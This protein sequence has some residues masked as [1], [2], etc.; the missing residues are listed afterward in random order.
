MTTLNEALTWLQPGNKTFGWGGLLM[1]SRNAVNNALID[2]YLSRRRNPFVINEYVADDD[3]NLLIQ[4][5]DFEFG[6][7]YVSFHGTVFNDKVLKGYMDVISGKEFSWGKNNAGHYSIFKICSIDN[8]AD[9]RIEFPLEIKPAPVSSEGVMSVVAEIK[10]NS[11]YSLTGMWES[12]LNKKAGGV[13]V[14]KMTTLSAGAINYQL[15]TI[16]RSPEVNDE[17]LIR[18]QSLKC[19]VYE[20][21]PTSTENNSDY[22]DGA[23]I[24]YIKTPGL[25]EPGF[26]AGRDQLKYLLADDDLLSLTLSKSNVDKYANLSNR[27]NGIASFARDQIFPFETRVLHH[28][29]DTYLQGG[30]G[31]ITPQNAVIEVGQ[32]VSFKLVVAGVETAAD[33][34]MFLETGTSEKVSSSNQLV[35]TSSMTNKKIRIIAT[36]KDATYYMGIAT[37]ISSS[38]T[39][40]PLVMVCSQSTR[41]YK[42]DAK[43]TNNAQISVSVS[44]L[45]GD[46][47]GTVTYDNTSEEYRYK[48]GSLSE[49]NKGNNFSLDCISFTNMTTKVVQKCYALCVYFNPAE[50]LQIDYDSSGLT[51]DRIP[52]YVVT[53]DG[54]FK[55]GDLDWND[56]TFEVLY[57]GGFIDKNNGVY[58]R[59]KSEVTD[60]SILTSRLVLKGRAYFGFVIIPSEIITPPGS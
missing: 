60:F 58:T 36:L 18:P 27:D 59:A 22:G 29:G 43:S 12:E 55:P 54:M 26:P 7:P 23:V 34:R 21:N 39:V 4:L 9:K 32:S 16:I 51:N 35:A 11:D 40:N 25:V 45:K 42:V 56:Y 28:S 15:C 50:A 17:Q 8:L 5:T 52:F 2:D 14:K 48:I 46:V 24:V 41:G 44:N 53:Q 38:L 10:S 33:W 20:K 37:V 13:T 1:I 30:V 49:G 31:V 19:G 57:G 47:A 6:P 3:N